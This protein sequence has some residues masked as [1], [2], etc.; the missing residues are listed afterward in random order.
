MKFLTTLLLIFTVSTLSIQAKVPEDSRKMSTTGNVLVDPGFELKN[1][2][3]NV[4]GSSVDEN[5]RTGKHGLTVRNEE[6]AWNGAEQI[7]VLPEETHRVYVSGWIKTDS[8]VQGKESWENARISIEFHDENGNL[9][10]GYPPVTGQAVGTTDWTFY[11][12]SYHASSAARKI[13]IQCALGNATGTAYFDDISLVIKDKKK[14]I[15]QAGS[16]SGVMEEGEWYALDKKNSASGSYFVDWSGLLD[17]PAGKHG[18]LTVKDGRFEFQDGTPARFW[19]TNLVGPD[20]FVSDAQVDSMVSRL[21]KMGCNLLRLHHMDAPWSDPNIFGNGKSTRSLADSSMRKLDYLIH[22]CKEAGIY[23]FMDLLVHRE[24]TEE[25]GI[26]NRPNDLGGKQ[27]GFF[28]EKIVELQKEFATQLFNHVNQFTKVAYKD[29]PAIVAADFINE[30][31]VFTHFTGDILTPAYREELTDLWK[32]SEYK[33][34][35]LAIFGVDWSN[36]KAKLIE[37]SSGADIKESIRFLSSV[38]QSYYK[39]M[40]DTLRTLGVKFPLSGSNMPLPILSLLKNNSIMDFTCNNEYWDHPQVW[41]VGDDWERILEAPFHNRSQLKNPQK[42]L[43]HSKSYFKVDGKP[44][45]ITEWNHCYPNEYVLESVPLMAAY[46]ALQ[47]WDGVL[48]FDYNHHVPG[49]DRIR[50]YT[51]SVQPEDMAGWVMAAPL[52]LRGDVKKAP[53]LVVEKISNDQVNSTPSYSTFLDENYHLPFVTRVAKSF[54]AEKA[55]DISAYEK[56]FDRDS[57]VIKS[58]TGELLYNTK[59]GYFRIDAPRVQGA[60]GFVG[61]RALDFPLFSFKLDNTHASLFAVSRDGKDLVGSK[62][63]YLVVIPPAK[64]KGQVYDGAR[65]LLKDPGSDEVLVQVV[66]GSLSFK[67]LPGKKVEVF[68]L[69]LDGTRGKQL[70]IKK[71]KGTAGEIDLSKGRALVYEVVVK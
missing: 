2:A 66:N 24:F 47:G 3:W 27:V 11:R 53:G 55:A 1:A 16:L 23:I 42:N 22:R 17:A 52:F 40:H 20:C 68:P 5:A 45:I 33:D 50:N 14:N 28:S 10:Q 41:K 32:A 15:L 36:D 19:G 18:F 44:F 65:N 60:A 56:Y 54:S 39:E 29:E 67:K 37:A 70:K 9:V 30:S 48:Q 62:H 71:A 69:S 13:K 25:D 8:V 21:S 4:F 7:V 38:E 63:F 31:N 43:V 46:G 26:E 51:V 35:Q 12:R 59:T 34:K 6:P 61:G 49:A 58:E 57:G 64:M